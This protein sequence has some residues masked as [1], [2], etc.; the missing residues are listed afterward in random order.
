MSVAGGGEEVA[1]GR[2]GDAAD[3][4]LVAAEDPR[5]AAVVEVGGE[6]PCA[7]PVGRGR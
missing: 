4:G 5:Q 3:G 6:L 7:P 2:E 1:A